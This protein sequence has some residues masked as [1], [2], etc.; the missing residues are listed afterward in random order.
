MVRPWWDHFIRINLA[1]MGF[2]SLV[3]IGKQTFSDSTL[4]C[5]PLPFEIK[6]YNIS[7]VSIGNSSKTSHTQYLFMCNTTFQTLHLKYVQQNCLDKSGFDIQRYF[8]W[9]LS[10]FTLLVYLISI[11]WY[12][13]PPFSRRLSELS[14][15]L[16]VM[17][18]IKLSPKGM[19]HALRPNPDD[20]IDRDCL[21]YTSPS[22]RD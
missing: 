2:T 11:S 14:R 10:G 20:D 7:Q 8:G 3:I 5:L 6:Q 9:I 13:Y 17:E 19:L 12:V 16:E 22:P 15:L 21:L 1:L 18:E 4:S